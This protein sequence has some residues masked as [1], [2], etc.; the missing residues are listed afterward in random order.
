MP[1]PLVGRRFIFTQPDGATLEVRGWGNQR[2][3]RF[4]TLD[5]Y[6]VAR[7]SATGFFQYATLSADGDQLI[8]TGVCP[9]V[10]DPATLGLRPGLRIMRDAARRLSNPATR[11][12][13]RWE[14]RLDEQGTELRSAMLDGTLP[15]REPPIHPTV[16]NYVG[17]C[18]LIQFPGI[19]GIF[20]PEE[21][22]AYCNQ[23]GYLKF[24]NHGS[25]RD[26]FNDNSL[27]KLQ[28]T[29]VVAPY[30]TAKKP[31][32]Y[33]TDPSITYGERAA[34]LVQEALKHHKSHGFDFSSLSTDTAGNVYAVNALYAGSEKDSK[35]NQGLW[36]HQDHLPYPFELSPLKKAH[37]YQ[38]TAMEDELTLGTFCHENGHMLCTFPDLYDL[39]DQS[40]GTGH[41]C[42][43]GTGG[44]PDPHN[45]CQFSAYLKH[46]AGWASS[47]TPIAPGL[48][49][50]ARAFQNDFFLFQKNPTEY[51]IVENRFKSGRD[52]AL[53][54]SGLAIWH[55][56]EFGSNE[57][58]QM[59]PKLHYRCALMQ[60]DGQ[61]HLELGINPGDGLDLF[62]SGKS[63]RF[64]DST[65]PS[66]KWWDGMPSKL[67]IHSIGAPGM[68]MSFA[69]S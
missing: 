7:E 6:T 54:D 16:G 53:P 40:Y 33:Y 11:T 14:E 67:H 39:G 15:R 29:N 47:V 38:I 17:L 58:E 18:L 61:N 8:P 51:F 69:T 57:N 42:L 1:F 4:E 63:N 65:N 48:K 3:L 9:G 37:D 30:Y 46:R 28:Y 41:F 34:E 52:Q 25:V 50:S 62:P 13:T 60:A 24:G 31:Q 45:P 55:V 36:P 66:S 26:Y 21:V 20:S 49:F 10:V 32:S 35:L 56:D 43:M 44:I 12:K 27:G 23:R 22:D 2:L 59:T 64:N 68:S 5:G 19:P